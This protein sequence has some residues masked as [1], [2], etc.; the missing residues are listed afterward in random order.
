[1]VDEATHLA[2]QVAVRVGRLSSVVGPHR[3]DLVLVQAPGEE[4]ELKVVA[5]APR[6]EG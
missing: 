6:D 2:R 3:D 5:R 1:L 4:A